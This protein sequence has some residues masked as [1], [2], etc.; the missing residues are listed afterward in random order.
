VGPFNIF[1]IRAIL[2][3]AIA[4]VLARVFHPEFDLVTVILL[5]VL[6][7]GLAYLLEYFRKRKS[8]R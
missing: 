2:G 8:N 6:L 1:M 4:V 5:G 7:V 3:G